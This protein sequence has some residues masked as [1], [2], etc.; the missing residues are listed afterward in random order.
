V[1]AVAEMLA[2]MLPTTELLATWYLAEMGI[3]VV[4]FMLSKWLRHR[5]TPVTAPVP[6]TILLAATRLVATELLHRDHVA[7][8][9]LN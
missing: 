4:T 1:T 3:Q 7:L 2:Y 8:H 6:P 5:A 9:H